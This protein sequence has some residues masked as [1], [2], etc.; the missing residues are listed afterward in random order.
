M[1]YGM[2][3]VHKGKKNAKKFFG[4]LICFFLDCLDN[5]ALED[6]EKRVKRLNEEFF[7]SRDPIRRR[8]IVLELDM[9]ESALCS[10]MERINRREAPSVSSGEVLPSKV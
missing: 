6:A 4:F 5:W 2:S 3:V 10:I 7:D 9:Q 1:D 8:Q